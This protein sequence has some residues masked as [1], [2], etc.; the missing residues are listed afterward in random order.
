MEVLGSFTAAVFVQL[1]LLFYV[2]GFL[3]RN[4]LYLRLL[5]LAGTC[6]YILYYYF[7]TDTPLWDAIWT[8][9]VIGVTN[10]A[11]ILVILRERTTVGMSKDMLKLYQSFPTLY[12]GQFRKIMKRADWITA[13]EDTEICTQGE[14][15]AN[16]YLVSQ[17]NVSIRRGDKIVSIGAGNF[18]GEI[19]FLTGGAAS[20]TVTAAK[21]TQYVRWERLQLT[22]L[23]ERSPRLSNALRAL[24]NQDIARKLAVSWPEY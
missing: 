22:Q 2:L 14:T 16:L 8:S 9:A 19:S 10:L 20:A 23:M 24:F 21:G 15:L 3:T 5:L 12:P 18:L 6:F 7:V 13:A 11:L 4:E 17:G 1:A